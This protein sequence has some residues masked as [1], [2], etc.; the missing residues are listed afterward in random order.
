MTT[1]IKRTDVTKAINADRGSFERAVSE[2]CNLSTRIKEIKKYLSQ[3]GYT[4][5][6]LKQKN[7]EKH[8]VCKSLMSQLPMM[9][10]ETEKGVKYMSIYRYD[11][12]TETNVPKKWTI[13]LVLQ[14]IDKQFMADMG[15]KNIAD[16][17]KAY[18]EEK[19]MEEAKKAAAKAAAIEA[20]EKAA[21]IE[22]AKREEVRKE[23]RGSKAAA[24][25]TTNKAAA[26][27]A[28]AKKNNKK[29]A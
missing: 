6:Y 11:K 15:T 5:A 19:A 4:I 29:A 13:A 17:I 21:A 22:E 16:A 2:L 1:I 14:C 9:E 12:K 7:E 23:G 28:A 27:K 18:Q 20:A 24:K 26:I 10:F 3:R 25:K 8:L